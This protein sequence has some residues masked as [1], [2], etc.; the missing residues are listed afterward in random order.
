MGP[1]S[2]THRRIGRA[3]RLPPVG[4]SLTRER[5][6]AGLRCVFQRV[7][8]E[9]ATSNGGRDARLYTVAVACVINDV[10]DEFGLNAGEREEVLGQWAKTIDLAES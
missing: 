7:Q 10:A 9:L 1:T 8:L 6:I 2:N 4:Q 5:L 3:F